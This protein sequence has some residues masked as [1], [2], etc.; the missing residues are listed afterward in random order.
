MIENL[1]VKIKIKFDGDI[2]IRFLYQL[3]LQG[4]DVEN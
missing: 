1:L 2:L 3:K 4:K